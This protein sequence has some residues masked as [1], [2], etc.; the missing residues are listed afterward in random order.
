MFSYI[1]RDQLRINAETQDELKPGRKERRQSPDFAAFSKGNGIATTSQADA[2]DDEHV[3]V[4]EFVSI[5]KGKK[6]P[7]PA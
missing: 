7:N 2:H 6:A 4:L 5:G 3:L 1:P